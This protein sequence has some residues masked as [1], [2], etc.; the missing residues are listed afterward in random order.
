MPSKKL[1]PRELARGEMLAAA[2]L[3]ATSTATP[4]LPT[5]NVVID[6]TKL[7]LPDLSLLARIRRAE[8]TDDEVLVMLDRVV[9]GGISLVP[10]DALPHVLQAVHAVVYKASEPETPQGN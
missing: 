1:Q 9:V 2:P 5:V 4:V 8:A 6:R 7:L 10:L 3:P